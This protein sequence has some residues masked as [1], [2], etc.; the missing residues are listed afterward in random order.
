MLRTTAPL[1]SGGSRGWRVRTSDGLFN[2]LGRRLGYGL[3]G[4]GIRSIRLSHCGRQNRAM[5]NE[6]ADWR[7]VNILVA[8]Y[9]SVALP[10]RSDIH[11]LRIRATCASLIPHVG[12]VAEPTL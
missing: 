3:H 4:P 12:H 2:A 8:R 5:R 1:P 10:E 7:Y 6:L 11:G 9:D